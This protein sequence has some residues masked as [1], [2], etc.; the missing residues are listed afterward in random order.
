VVVIFFYFLLPVLNPAVITHP[1]TVDLNP[2]VVRTD[3]DR[4]LEPAVMTHAGAVDVVYAYPQSR[5]LSAYAG[6]LLVN[7]RRQRTR[8]WRCCNLSLPPVRSE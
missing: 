6:S 4:I 1:I 8:L 3:G 5:H 7:S 2:T